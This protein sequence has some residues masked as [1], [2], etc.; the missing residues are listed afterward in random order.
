M[1]KLME[2][3][4]FMG[5]AE[6]GYL[7][8]SPASIKLEQFCRELIEEFSL[9]KNS[10]HQ[11]VF[12]CHSQNTDAIMDEKLLHY[13]FRNLL[14]NA[15]KYSH[16]GTEIKFELNC[17]LADGVAIF[18]V[19]DQGIG[20]PT[21]DQNRIFDSF[22]RAS[23]VQSIHGHGLGLVIVKKCVDAHNGK[24]A[25]NSQLGLGTTFTVT[26]PLNL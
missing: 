22:Y 16:P 11:I 7:V 14:S 5:K 25:I 2:D 4:L 12:T 1:E 8:Y 19:Q 23:N 9:I 24:I 18:Q 17:N 3:V 15:A 13:L 6:A 21:A 20:I 26:L 10:N